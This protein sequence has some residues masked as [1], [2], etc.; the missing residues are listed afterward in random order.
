MTVFG[1]PTPKDDIDG[2]QEAQVYYEEKD[3]ERIERYCKKDVVALVHLMMK[4]K[5]EELIEEVVEV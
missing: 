5:R 1:I 3:L 4:Y 2:S